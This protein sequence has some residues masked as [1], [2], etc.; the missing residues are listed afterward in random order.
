LQMGLVNAVVPVAELE[1][2]VADI[3]DRL[4]DN[5]P[6]SMRAT[7]LTVNELTRDAATRNE[8]L[9]DSLMSACFNSADYTEGRKA[10][11]EKRK[12]VFTGK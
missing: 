7:K 10:F 8:D 5:A 12:P 1:A 3:T 11:M 4:V 2:A 9:L 6:L